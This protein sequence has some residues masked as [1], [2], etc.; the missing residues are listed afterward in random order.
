M[1][2]DFFFLKYCTALATIL[3][4]QFMYAMFRSIKFNIMPRSWKVQLLSYQRC[5]LLSLLFNLLWDECLHQFANN[6]R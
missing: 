2:P 3:F 4:E 6:F 5:K 1:L